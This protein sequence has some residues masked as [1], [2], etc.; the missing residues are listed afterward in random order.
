MLVVGIGIFENDN[1]AAFELT[2]RQNL[3]VPGTGSA[4][5]EFVYEQVIAD[6]QGAFHGSRGDLES[7]NDKACA[8][9]GPDYRH[10]ERLQI[11]GDGRLVLVMLMFAL[12]LRF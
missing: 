10:E 8:E 9:Q 5:N 6:Q 11:F 4:E 1:V 7:L 3:L 12:R 2:I